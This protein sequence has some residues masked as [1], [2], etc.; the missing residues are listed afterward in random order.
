MPF[1]LSRNGRYVAFISSATNLSPNDLDAVPDLYVKDLVT[2]SLQL[3]STNASGVKG[4]HTF[5]TSPVISN[6][7]KTVLFTLDASNFDPRQI[8][9]TCF[10]RNQPR[11]CV[12]REVY[13]KRLDTGGIRL[14]TPPTGL[15]RPLQGHRHLCRQLY[16][17][18]LRQR[19]SAPMGH[20]F[21]R[22]RCLRGEP[23]E[24]LGEAGIDRAAGR[25]ARRGVRRGG[26]RAIFRGRIRVVFTISPNM[27]TTPNPWDPRHTAN[28]QQ[29]YLKDV[30]SSALTLISVNTAGGYG[31][32]GAFESRISPDGMQ[33]S[34]QT[35]ADNL[36]PN[37]TDT[38]QD[39]HLRDLAADTTSLISIR[40]DGVKADANSISSQPVPARDSVFFETVVGEFDTDHNDLYER[41]AP[42]TVA[43]PDADA[44]GVTDDI[45]A[46]GGVG[47]SPAGAFSD[48]TGGGL[49]TSGQSWMQQGL[50][51]PSLTQPPRRRRDHGRPWDRRCPRSPCAVVSRSR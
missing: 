27:G 31:N 48:D 19:S 15:N 24:R 36:D 45:D 22:R 20:G 40:S 39:I 38:F 21:S 8:V 17:R 37:D 11:P 9:H 44:D 42:Y 13:A 47:N 1:S 23:R 29:V 50:R 25:D 35:R 26:R 43:N 4:N 12:D 2:G 5:L 33:V 46:D 28:T 16:R 18:H 14:L 10:I 30:T 41:V 34:F 51:W 32:Q 7:G 6:D 3:A 49:M